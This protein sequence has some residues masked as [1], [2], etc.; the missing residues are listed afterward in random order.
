MDNPLVRKDL[1]ESIVELRA[2]VERRLRQN[3]YYVAMHKL[4]ELLAAIRPLDIIEGEANP[5]PA[6]PEPAAEPK[7]AAPAPAAEASA[8][9][10]AEETQASWQPASPVYAGEAQA[11]L[12]AAP[13]EATANGLDAA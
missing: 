1:V 3:Q 10:A 5:A 12:S 9:T 4:D 7:V 11:G 2:E 13:A 8:E 6:A